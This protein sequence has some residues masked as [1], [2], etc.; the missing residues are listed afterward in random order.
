MGVEFVPGDRARVIKNGGVGEVV[1]RANTH[2]VVRVWFPAPF[3]GTQTFR[4][5]ELEPA[6]PFTARPFPRRKS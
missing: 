2:G 6:A 5:D 1:G 4:F 3:N